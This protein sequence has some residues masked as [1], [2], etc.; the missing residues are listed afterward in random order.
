MMNPPPKEHDEETQKLNNDYLKKGGEITYCAKGE[1][2]E[3][4]DFKG[5]YYTKRKK[6]KEEENNK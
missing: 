5:G 6:K 1:R 2:S 3:S 4:I